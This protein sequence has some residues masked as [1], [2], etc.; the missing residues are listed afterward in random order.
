MSNCSPAD[1]WFLVVLF[2]ENA[3][4]INQ[5]SMLVGMC[6]MVGNSKCPTSFDVGGR[7]P[8]FPLLSSLVLQTKCTSVVGGIAD[9]PLPITICILLTFVCW[10]CV[11]RWVDADVPH[12]TGREG[13]GPSH[14]KHTGD[15]RCRKVP[16]LDPPPEP[17]T[18]HTYLRRQSCFPLLSGNVLPTQFGSSLFPK[19]QTTR[20]AQHVCVT[21]VSPCH[22]KERGAED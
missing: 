12:C 17:S 13:R 9:S 1:L 15:T 5:G 3:S 8:D 18:L 20:D 19:H 11:A 2:E 16:S 22:L 21:L 7:A 4:R 10:H 14:F 6:I